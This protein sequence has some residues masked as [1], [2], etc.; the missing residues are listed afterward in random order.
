MSVYMCV[1]LCVLG[2]VRGER[3]KSLRS[4]DRDP[5]WMWRGGLENGER[6]KIEGDRG[7]EG[8]II[9]VVWSPRG[10]LIS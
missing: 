7:G 9:A 5:W 4:G 1:C 2:G 6:V 3:R 10:R 8:E